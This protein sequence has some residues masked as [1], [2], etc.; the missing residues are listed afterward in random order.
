MNPDLSQLHDIHLPTSVAWWPLA[1]G[2]WLLL[3]LL[4]IALLLGYGFY[5]RYRQQR[6]RREALALL[7]QLQQ[8][9]LTPQA[10]V[11][12]YSQLLRRVAISRFPRAEVAAL[13]G[14]QWLVF[15]DQQMK[16]PGFQQQGRMLITAPYSATVEG[17][18]GALSA[19]CER[20]IA[21][22]A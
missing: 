20:W 4:V 18:L 13:T 19:L 14:E 5:R 17:D 12:E 8:Q 21:G 1:L 2:W 16:V 6:W 9:S 3:A 11:V 7:R 22:V 15:L 10:L